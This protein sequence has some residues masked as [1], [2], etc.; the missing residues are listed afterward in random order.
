MPRKPQVGFN[1]GLI[2]GRGGR[3][4]AGLAEGTVLRRPDD[5]AAAVRGLDGRVQV[6]VVVVGDS[7]GVFAV[8]GLDE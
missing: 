2:V 3:G 7:V 4:D 1:D 8:L 5:N 6:V